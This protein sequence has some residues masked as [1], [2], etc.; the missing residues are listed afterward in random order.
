MR[1]I[2][3]YSRARDRTC[4]DPCKYAQQSS[5]LNWDARKCTHPV[6]WL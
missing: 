1:E 3:D 4:G 2:G 5:P 6:F